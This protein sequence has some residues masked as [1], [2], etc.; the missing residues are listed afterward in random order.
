MKKGSLESLTKFQCFVF[1]NLEL[2]IP[3]RE[4]IHF[5]EKFLICGV[6]YCECSTHALRESD[7]ELQLTSEIE[8]YAICSVYVKSARVKGYLLASC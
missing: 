2:R 6:K 7:C 5:G 8:V 3:R 4:K 1:K